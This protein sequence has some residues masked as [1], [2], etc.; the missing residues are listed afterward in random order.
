MDIELV[1][2]VSTIATPLLTIAGFALLKFNDFKHLEKD[3]TDII[4]TQATQGKK[5]NKIDKQVAVLTQR[6][7]TLEKS[8]K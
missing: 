8:K 2:T 1:K 5:L 3:V 4:D 6:T 7:K